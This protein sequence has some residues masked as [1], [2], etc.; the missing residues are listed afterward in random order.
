MNIA[1][2][3]FFV[4]LLF[5][6]NSHAFKIASQQKSDVI[7]ALVHLLDSSE[8]LFIGEVH[9]TND[10]HLIID[11]MKTLAEHGVKYLIL[12]VSTSE[13]ENLQNFVRTGDAKIFSSPWDYLFSSGSEY[14]ALVE[15]ATK[16]KIQVIPYDHPQSMD[17]NLSDA[18]RNSYMAHQLL[19][20][21][22]E[23]K[24]LIITGFA[25]AEFESTP[26]QTARRILSQTRNTAAVKLESAAG[27]ARAIQLGM[28]SK[29]A[30]SMSSA[31]TE[32]SESVFNF[33]DRSFAYPTVALESLTYL[34]A[35]LSTA[36]S[37]VYSKYSENFDYVIFLSEA[38][39]K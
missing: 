1:N 33:P 8:F 4:V 25:H 20:L 31:F 15:A 11:N 23:G 2:L 38:D 3:F 6:E 26:Y 7:P 35:A 29:F 16:Q 34:S 30:D 32:A 12:E 5:S 24:K 37:I 17:K 19:E 36:T 22:R 9:L 13:S 39:S 27:K 14:A 18:D 28:P 10:E 21:P